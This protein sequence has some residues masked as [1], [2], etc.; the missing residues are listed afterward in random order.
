ML[1]LRS[2]IPMLKMQVVSAR[3]TEWIETSKERERNPD[4]FLDGQLRS[5]FPITPQSADSN[6]VLTRG[7]STV[8]PT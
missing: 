3:R 4:F 5:A 8:C 2:R 7:E 6:P 1:C